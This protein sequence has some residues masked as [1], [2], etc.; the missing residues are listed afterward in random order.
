MKNLFQLLL[1]SIIL[2]L[3]ISTNSNAQSN[4]YEEYKKLFAERGA[5]A[6]PDGSLEVVLTI[7]DDDKTDCYLAK[8]QVVNNQIVKII[9]ILLDDGTVKPL[10]G[11]LASRYTSEKNPTSLSR[12]I[13]NGMSST[14]LS[15]DDKLIN[16]F[17]IK[18]L[19]QKADVF[20]KAPSADSY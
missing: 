5:T 16:I 15:D 11:K 7:R 10:E 13:K 9:G 20:K 17:F 14:I 6:I 1:V 8:V 12:E 19:K 18:Q 3:G 4:C 2:I